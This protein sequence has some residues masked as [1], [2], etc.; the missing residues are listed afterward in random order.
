M[1]KVLIFLFYLTILNS[2]FSQ[3]NNYLIENFQERK[4]TKI[5]NELERNNIDSILNNI[6]TKYFNANKL[7]ILDKLSKFTKEVV[8]VKSKSKRFTSLS[9]P[10]GFNDYMFRYIDSTG[11][12]LQI[13]LLFKYN[14]INSKIFKI[15]TLD[16]KFFEKVKKNIDKG[17]HVIFIGKEP[18][19]QYPRNTILEYRNCQSDM[20]TVTFG[21]QINS[22]KNWVEGQGN[23][24]KNKVVNFS[25]KYQ[26]DS[27]YIRQN[28]IAIRNA[29][30]KNF[31]NF[32][33][34]GEMYNKTPDEEAIW[35]M[36][37]FSQ[38]QQNGDIKIFAA[39]KITFEGKDARI[40]A[41]RDNPKI[42]NVEFILDRLKLLKIE[43]DLK[44]ATRPE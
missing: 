40:E 27:N 18:K 33:M 36:H 1:K 13:E 15:E 28:I 26:L 8:K 10:I 19:V 11:T 32:S 22:F 3:D 7:K 17:P 21:S 14:D 37:L 4:A 24:D 25:P 41:N 6:D 42:I 9:F 30:P 39:Y 38:I 29:L 16:L 23:M 20:R 5:I 12:L 31:W 43:K 34:W 35:F 2:A 44:K